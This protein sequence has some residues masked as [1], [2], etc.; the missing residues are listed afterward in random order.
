VR[1][2][3]S[4]TWALR[5]FFHPTLPAV[6]A[7]FGAGA[8][9]VQSIFL[10]GT[11]ALAVLTYRQASKA[12]FLPLRTEVFKEQIKVFGKIQELFLEKD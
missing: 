7:W 3:P 1:L 5:N 8:N 11:L 6:A 9:A 2:I 4:R 12:I 10:V